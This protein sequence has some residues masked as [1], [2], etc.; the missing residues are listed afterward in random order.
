MMRKILGVITGY[1][2]FVVTSLVFFKLSGHD[3]HSDSATIFIILTAAYGALFS[4]ISGFIT[5][6]IARTK[7]LKT[8]FALALIIAGFAAF[9]FFKSGGS[10]WTQ[11]LA[12]FIFAPVSILGGLFYN[13][14]QKDNP[15]N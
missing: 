8:N 15:G 2:F 1:A 11:T 14:R 5:Q 10:H 4:F 9:S 3:P 7:K 12:I 13:K 6:L